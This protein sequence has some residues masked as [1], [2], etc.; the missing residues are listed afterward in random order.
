LWNG[1]GSFLSQAGR[2]AIVLPDSILSNP[3]LLYIRRWILKHCRV[4]A[5]VDLPAETFEAF[6]GTGTKTSVLVLQKKTQEQIQFEEASERMEDYEVFMVICQTMGYDRRGNDLWLR[7]P[8]GEIIEQEVI[9][10]IVT[11]TPEGLVIHEPKK[12]RRPIRDDDVA[13]V[14]PLFEKWLKEKGLLRWLNP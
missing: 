9:S 11:R 4:L 1:V 14:A 10:H 7:T 12:E 8:E 2:M 3:G 5:S 13:Q 6:G